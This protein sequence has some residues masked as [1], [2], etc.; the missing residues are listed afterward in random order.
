[1]SLEETLKQLEKSVEEL[2]EAALL[3]QK[4]RKA[5]VKELKSAVKTAREKLIQ[6][7][8]LISP[9]QTSSKK[10]KKTEDEQTENTQRETP[11][12]GSVSATTFILPD[13]PENPRNDEVK[14]I[15]TNENEEGK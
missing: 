9:A 4:R 7:V 11:E 2:E 3:F 12:R 1:M 5:E 8:N 6:A 15:Q 13:N 10:G 14:R